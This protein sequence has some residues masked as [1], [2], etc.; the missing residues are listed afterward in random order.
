M[1][2]DAGKDNDDER[3]AC[4]IPT[5][6]ADLSPEAVARLVRRVSH[7]VHDPDRKIDPFDVDD[8]GK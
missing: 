4:P 3:T 7:A 6:Q 2:L 5:D 8:P 1:S